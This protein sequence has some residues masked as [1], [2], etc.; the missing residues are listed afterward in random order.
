M[1]LRPFDLNQ[2]RRFLAEWNQRRGGT[3]QAEIVV[4]ELYEVTRGHPL[5]VRLT[6]QSVDNVYRRDRLIPSV[7]TVFDEPAPYNEPGVRPGE[8]IGE[9]LLF[10]FLQRFRGVGE[11]GVDEHGVAERTLTRELLAVLAAPR[12]LD[13]A[14][15]EA[16]VPQEQA[17]KIWARLCRYSFAS[18]VGDGSTVVLHPLLRDLLAKQLQTRPAGTRPSYHEVHTRLHHYYAEQGRFEDMLYHALA[19]EE[20][21]E[22]ATRLAPRIGA[23][24]TEWVETLIAITEAPMPPKTPAV[25]ESRLVHLLGRVVRQSTT[26]AN[27][28]HVAALVRALWWLRSCTSARRRTPARY[29]DV[30]RGFRELGEEAIPA[31]TAWLGEYR[32]LLH[33]AED[34]TPAGPAPQLP[35]YCRAGVSLAYPRVWPRR[36]TIRKTAAGLVVV[37]LAGYVLVYANHTSQHCDRFGV[38]NVGAVASTLWDD[39]FTLSKVDH[40]QCVGLADTGG[41][42]AYGETKLSGDDY[43]VEQLTRLIQEQNEQVLAEHN[44]PGGRSYVTIVV[45]T[46]LSSADEPP[47]RDLSAGVNEL[48]G[49]YLTQRDWNRFAGPDGGSSSLLPRN[50][51]LRVIPANFGGNSVY[52]EETAARIQELAERDPTVVAVT[53]MGQT[54]EETLVAAELLG[55]PEGEWQGIPVVG[56]VPSGTGF[57]GKPAFFRTAPTNERQTQV[58]IEFALRDPRFAN[59]RPY[60]FADP[61]D[62]YSSDLKI[63]YERAIQAA[64]YGG[65]SPLSPAQSRDYEADTNNTATSL[66]QNIARMCQDAD[67]NRADPLLIY[68]GRTNEVP[69]LLD[70]LSR[71]SCGQRTLVLGA[72]D[73]SQL[74]TANYADLRSRAEFVDGRLFFTTFGADRQGWLRMRP[75]SP[76]PAGVDRYFNDYEQMRAAGAGRTFRSPSNGHI[77]LSYDAVWVVLDAVSRVEAVKGDIHDRRLLRDTLRQ[78]TGDNAFTGVTGR[79]DFG[80]PTAPYSEQRGADAQEKLVVVQNVVADQDGLRSEYQFSAGR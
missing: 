25:A 15:I 21:Q 35:K 16:L 20:V 51:L 12:R 70:E 76:L 50:P 53:G 56:S 37:L 13:V 7:R 11:R 31:V 32:R 64:H 78:T 57:T 42:F 79:I 54:R 73:L 68:T 29:D 40:G 14:T 77:M 18:R 60:L 38:L 8:T 17:T 10:K 41:L 22:V 30:V 26:R 59:R 71:S 61:R 23:G 36:N 43:E 28:T 9:F 27:A 80:P 75:D 67:A 74:E 49:A 24:K 66:G 6:A 44:S 4:N 45:A 5:A 65:N 63:N 69:T 52:A 58:A 2:V 34:N 48:R 39:S 55:K 19:L 47:K 46:M 1:R 33:A 3:G 62:N 72:D